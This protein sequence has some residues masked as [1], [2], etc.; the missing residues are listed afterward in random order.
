MELQARDD[1]NKGYRTTT[2]PE[3]LKAEKKLQR[4]LFYVQKD[5]YQVRSYQDVLLPYYKD[6]V[7]AL[8]KQVILKEGEAVS[9]RYGYQDL[10]S[11]LKSLGLIGGNDVTKVCLQALEPR[12]K[13]RPAHRKPVTRDELLRLGCCST[14]SFG[15][16]I[17]SYGLMLSA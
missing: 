13:K 9:D 15:V 8:Y 3:V 12:Y 11:W 14:R 1:P 4:L 5:P 17:G 6:E 7:F 16:A 10:A 2:Y